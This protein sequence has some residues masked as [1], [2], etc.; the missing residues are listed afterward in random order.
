MKKKS[1]MKQIS[2]TPYYVWA[3]LFIIVP[4]IYV[5]YYT[6]TDANGS[7]SFFDNFKVIGTYS[8]TFLLSIMMALIATVICLVIGYPLAL[9]ISRT[10]P[11]TQKI[12]IMLVMLP[13]WINF[14]IRT[15]SIAI[16]LEKNGLINQ[17]LGIFGVQLNLMD[18]RFAVVVG[19]VYDFLPYMILPIYSVLTKLDM[20]LVEAA[21]D[22][23]C[24][25]FQAL[26]KVIVP[27]SVSGIISGITMV[28][29]PCVSTFYISQ[30]LGGTNTYIIGDAIEARML[31]IS[32]DYSK[33]ATL[34]FVLMILIVVSTLIM[35]HYTDDDDTSAAGGFVA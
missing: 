19:M 5:I 26:I 3:A 31:S 2:A 14:I 27:L 30:R 1:F 23:G 11:S 17:F 10:K 4:I 35:N 9:A 29:V 28:F 33:G 15:D 8:S 16:L 24:N 12:L 20:K 25:A 7:F 34:S 22:L 13:M 18:T 32:A 21:R 6:F